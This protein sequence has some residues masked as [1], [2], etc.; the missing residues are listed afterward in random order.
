MTIIIDAVTIDRVC[1]AAFVEMLVL[2]KNFLLNVNI[3]FTV[4]LYNIHNKIPFKTFI[5]F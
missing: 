3:P 4:C 2:D 5:T 1:M